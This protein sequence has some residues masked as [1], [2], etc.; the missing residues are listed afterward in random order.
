MKH[1]CEKIHTKIHE[2][3]RLW[4]LSGTYVDNVD[5]KKN[6]ERKNEQNHLNLYIFQPL[7]LMEHRIQKVI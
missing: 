6:I 5:I 1:A 2:K 3:K 7:F 4:K